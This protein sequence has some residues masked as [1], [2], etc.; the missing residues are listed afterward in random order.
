VG[1]KRRAFLQQTALALTALGVSESALSL[2][3]DQYQKA[4]AQ[5]TQR[6]LAL[7]VGINQYPEQVCDFTSSRGTALTGCLTDV[8][9]QR[10]LLI[11][12]FGFQPSDVLTLTDQQAT[13]QGIEDAFVSHLVEQARPNDVVI[14]HFSG[15]GSRVKLET[16][17][18]TDTEARHNTLVP[19]DGVLPTADNPVINDLFEETLSFLLQSL[20][21]NLVTTVLDISYVEPKQTLLGNLRIRSRPNAPSAQQIS[22]AEQDFQAQILSRMKASREQANAQLRAGQLPGVVLAATGANQI[23]AEAQWN[24][25]SAGLFTYAL[26]QQLWWSTPTTSMRFSLNQAGGTVEQ[27]VGNEQ[28]PRLSGQKADAPSLPPYFLP[29]DSSMGADGVVKAVE[30]DGKTVQL[31]LGGLPAA[32]VENYGTQSLLSLHQIGLVRVKPEQVSQKNSPGLSNMPDDNS[33]NTPIDK[34]D[35]S[36]GEAKDSE[37]LPSENLVSP[38]GEATTAT[39][40]PE[41]PESKVASDE[42]LKTTPS[43]SSTQSLQTRSREGLIVRARLCCGDAAEEDSGIKPGILVRESVRV[44]PRNVSLVVALDAS[45]ERIERVDATSALSAIPRVSSVVAGEH[46]ADCLFGKIQSPAPTVA[47]SASSDGGWEKN[48][49]AQGM[50]GQ[51]SSS[52]DGRYGLFYLSRTAIPNTVVES[53]EAVKTAI[54][55]LT[56]QLRILL[57]RKLLRLTANTGSSRLGVRVTLEMIAPQER[58]IMQQETTRAPWTPPESRLASLFIGEAS[59]PSV[60][61]N[62]RIQYRLQNYSDR[63][64]YCVFLG[65]DSNGNAIAVYPAVTSGN[66]TEN[67][68]SLGN[69]I[70]EPGEILLVPQASAASEWIVGNSTGLAETFVIFSG[71]PLTKTAATLAE[72]IR[73]IDSVRRPTILSNPL[74]VVQAILQ[75]LHR[76]SLQ[77]RPKFDIPADSYALDVNTWCNISFIYRIIDA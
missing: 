77:N 32:V 40:V 33:G 58:I 71:T 21:T 3:A 13:R 64:I 10:E 12:R 2:W 31:W 1:L 14:F 19:I 54:N 55:R 48:L 18:E 73:P 74:K 38:T 56:P 67:Q 23:A 60:P 75:D 9:L 51:S 41:S 4:L 5:P 43:R 45:L 53:D 50:S 66:N 27:L 8:A 15:L 59:V 52:N 28:Q 47:S 42:D 44:L 36:S 25:F 24:G 62:S 72:D 76:A 70:I 6:K 57:A 61:I 20:Q 34:V 69:S 17:L 29:P 26:T 68:S 22:S 65:L 30:A 16:D 46:P 49:F 35:Q 7:L 11:H 37:S 39:E 63:P